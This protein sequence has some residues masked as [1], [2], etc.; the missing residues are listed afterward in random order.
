METKGPYEQAMEEFEE[1]FPNLTPGQAQ[2]AIRAHLAAQD[3]R[4][5]ELERER[6]YLSQSLTTANELYRGCAIQLA[7]VRAR[8]ESSPKVWAGYGLGEGGQL[9]QIDKDEA[10]IRQRYDLPPEFVVRQVYAVPVEEQA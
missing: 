1:G 6:N 7:E 5:A 10:W 8:I 4:I 2:S 9:L 3:A